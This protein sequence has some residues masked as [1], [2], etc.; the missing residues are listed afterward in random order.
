MTMMAGLV[1]VFRDVQRWLRQGGRSA[2]RGRSSR[3]LLLEPLEDRCVPSTLDGTS[4]IASNF[5]GTA[6]P[7]GS[8]VW[9]TSAFK[10]NGAGSGPVSFQFTND[11]ISFSVNGTNTTVNAPNAEVTLS[12][13]ATTATTTFDTATNTWETT[14]PMHF[15]GNGFLDAVALPVPSGLP[16]GIKNVTWQGQ[17]SSD[18][19]G[20]NVN[21]QWAAA[22]YTTFGTDYNA[23][24]VKPTDDNH[25]SVYQNSD[26][27]GTPEAFLSYVVGG[28][29]GGG[30]SNFTGSLSGT[31][32]VRPV[33]LASLS[34]FVSTT[35]GGSV[36]GAVLTLTTTNSQGQTVTYTAT[37]NANGFFQFIGLLPGTY[38]LSVTPPPGFTNSSDQ[39]G[40]VNG[41]PSGT[42]G[43]GTISNINLGPGGV[44]I[45]YDFQEAFFFGGGS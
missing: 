31:A 16:G 19:S 20:L 10:I 43:N 27:A 5:N 38:T 6:I 30:G 29:T 21:W 40:T 23:L 18:T 13:S 2:R 37:T 25:V 1:R 36:S 45:N 24:N 7:A 41:T 34:G 12:P 22:V 4:A 28:A 32:S 11:T 26:H 8:T 35:A 3:P 44:G 42:P 14:L 15:S 39:A 17:F 33:V 9:F